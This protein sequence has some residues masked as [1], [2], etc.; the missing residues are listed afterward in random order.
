VGGSW[1]TTGCTTA[2][3]AAACT[4][5]RSVTSALASALD[6]GRLNSAT[7]NAAIGRVNALRGV[8]AKLEPVSSRR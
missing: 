2:L 5:G 3:I 1:A 4:Q 8:L 6:S 7:F